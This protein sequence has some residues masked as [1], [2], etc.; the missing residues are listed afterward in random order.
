MDSADTAI[1]DHPIPK[2]QWTCEDGERT[3]L[4]FKDFDFKNATPSDWVAF[5][6]AGPFPE[7]G[8]SR[9][10][11]QCL[12]D[13]LATYGNKPITIFETGMCFGTTTRMFLAKV[14]RDG[15]EI[16][17]CEMKPRDHFRKPMIE[18]G[19]WGKIN[20]HIGHS[21]MIPWDKEIDFLFIDSEHSLQDALGE[22]V[23]Y[24][25][26]LKT[27]G[28]VGFHD[29]SCCKGVKRAL[30]MIQELDHLEEIGRVDNG[31][32]AG[33]TFFRVTKKHRENIDYDTAGYEVYKGKN[34]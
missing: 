5:G 27:D 6:K 15:G 14:L 4:S 2:E 26:W 22:Y 13:A 25:M 34:G 18:M 21:Q 12:V 11:A 1:Y 33:I 19:L 9:A 8:I 24:R 3:L 32:D 16:H 10:E 23:R 30:A 28:I 20:I 7:P 31:A 29:T 17:T